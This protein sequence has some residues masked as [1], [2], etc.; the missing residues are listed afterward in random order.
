MS[1]YRIKTAAFAAF[2]VL[3]GSVQ[4][5]AASPAETAA[6]RHEILDA[7]ATTDT[8]Y[9]V[10]AQRWSCAMGME[11]ASVA[12][13]R[14]QG[15]EFFPDAADSCVTALARTARDRQFPTLYTRLLTELG[16]SPDRAGGLPQAIGPVVL[17]G[18]NKAAIGNDKVVVVTPAL[19]FD[20]GF[21]VAWQEGAANKGA[22]D[23]QQ[24]KAV[25]ENCLSQHL[26]TGTCFSV[27]YVQGARAFN[28]RS[29]AR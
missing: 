11:P 2:I 17:A 3:G 14:S 6:H 22:V 7:L 26:D 10:A 16:G 12:Q 19:A 9:G 18:T 23:G 13:A 8:P 25:T 29:A 27:G 5:W 20:A 28:A 4:G 24:L 15:A 21:A 1:N